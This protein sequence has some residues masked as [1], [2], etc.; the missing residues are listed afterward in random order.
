MANSSFMEMNRML[1]EMLQ[2][3]E[4]PFA[5]PVDIPF[6][7]EVSIPD[8]IPVEPIGFDSQTGRMMYQQCVKSGVLDPC[9]V[10]YGEVHRSGLIDPQHVTH[11]NGFHSFVVPGNCGAP[12]FTDPITGEVCWYEQDGTTIKRCRPGPVF[13]DPTS[14]LIR[15]NWDGV[16]CGGLCFTS[17]EE[18]MY[19]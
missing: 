10:S 9:F 16:G 19:Q 2:Q 8:A 5:E 15:V 3:E 6:A 13:T 4:T 17:S 11:A 18:I 7:E 12:T 1:G 14:G